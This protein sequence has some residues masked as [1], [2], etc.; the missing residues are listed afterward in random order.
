MIV[1]IRWGHKRVSLLVLLRDELI[2][3]HSAKVLIELGVWPTSKLWQSA[4]ENHLP[5]RNAAWRVIQ[6][7]IA[8][9]TLQ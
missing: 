2:V 1:G 7:F 9:F 5:Y 4:A 6:I 3:I 8:S